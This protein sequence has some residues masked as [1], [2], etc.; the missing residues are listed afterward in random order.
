MAWQ[1][2]IRQNSE[3]NPSIGVLASEDTNPIGMAVGLHEQ[4][5]KPEDRLAAMWISPDFRGK[6]IATSLI[7]KIAEWA[8]E[9]GCEALVT[10]VNQKNSH[11]KVF[12]TKLGFKQVTDQACDEIDL[13]LLL[14]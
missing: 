3:G 4:A 14:R 10:C 7:Q 8:G 9:S 2:Q 1:E 12:Y 5:D 6:G 13:R 11:T